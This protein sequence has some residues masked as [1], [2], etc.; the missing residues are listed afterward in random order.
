M[1]SCQFG[2]QLRR[3]GT[4]RI[5]NQRRGSVRLRCNQSVRKNAAHRAR[6]NPFGTAHELLRRI[7][8]NLCFL[9]RHSAGS[10]LQL[11]IEFLDML[12]KSLQMRLPGVLFGFEA[13]DP[14]FQ[15]LHA[16]AS[17]ER[18]L[19]HAQLFTLA[20]EHCLL[21]LVFE[22]LRA[23]LSRCQTGNARSFHLAYPLFELVHGRP[24]S[25]RLFTRL[26]R[27]P[28]ILNR[29]LLQL[30]FESS[31]TLMN[32]SQAGSARSFH[33]ADALFELLHGRPISLRLLSGL[34][35]DTFMLDGRLLQLVFKV[36]G[37][38]A[39]RRYICIALGFHRA[40]ALFEL[41]HGYQVRLRL[42]A[43]LRREFLVQDAR[44]LQLVFKIFRALLLRRHGR[45]ALGFHP[46]QALLKVVNGGSIGLHLFAGFRR[47]PLMP[48]G[49]PL[50]LFLEFLRALLKRGK[51]GIALG[52]HVAYALVKLLHC[53][54]M[55]LRLFL[56]LRTELVIVEERLV[57][58][59]FKLLCAA[60][61]GGYK[62]T[63]LSLHLA[64]PLL[65]LRHGDLIG[66]RLLAGLCRGLFVL[67]GR[68]LQLILQIFRAALS[69]GQIGDVLGFLVAHALFELLQGLLMSLRLV[70][71]QSRDL[72]AP[73]VRLL[74][75][76]FKL[77]RSLLSRGHIG[78]VL[79][80]HVAH[81]LFE[82]LQG[83][84]MGLGLFDGQRRGLVV[85]GARLLQLV[86]QFL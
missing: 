64:D 14:Q 79:G 53:H 11:I 6:R 35:P 51:I 82:L 44:S 78:T 34:N 85:L 5:G 60:L 33:L 13:V 72:V 75:F 41:L 81:T 22:V 47:D 36:L 24:M 7:H 59:F 27:E 55:S 9:R 25:L 39:Q 83:N 43:S 65:E 67:E 29:S 56:G 57:Q 62:G 52:F 2:Q 21:Q 70:V 1:N 48:H 69:R 71:G 49:R 12:F 38:L 77:P 63:A 26:R 74:Q 86:I 61:K 16:S 32:R 3:I 28:V 4:L 80:F 76:V 20:L 40:H 18:L 46:A 54:P 10:L 50:Q 15:L 23:L 19:V 58:L 31:R 66:L 8:G 42:F 37:A 45:N 84:P 17:F 68:L 73:K 30:V